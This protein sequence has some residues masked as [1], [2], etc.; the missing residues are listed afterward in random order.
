M[1]ILLCNRLFGGGGGGGGTTS[2]GRRFT[3]HRANNSRHHWSMIGRGAWQ[4]WFT[5]GDGRSLDTH[6]RAMD[7]SRGT[8][9]PGA[10]AC[11]TTSWCVPGREITQWLTDSSLSFPASKW[12][13]FQACRCC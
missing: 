13:S 4:V 3:H 1:L 7:H 8:S 12:N 5:P 10:R 2:S 9:H 6:L 11:V